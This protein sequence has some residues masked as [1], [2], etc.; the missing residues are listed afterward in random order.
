MMLYQ[1][2][3]IEKELKNS[4]PSEMFSDFLSVFLWATVV[5]SLPFADIL[6]EKDGFVNI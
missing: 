2:R 6:G 4:L 3:C 1:L 5:V